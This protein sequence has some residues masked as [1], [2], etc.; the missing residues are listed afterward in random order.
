MREKNDN[1]F[2][3]IQAAKKKLIESTNITDSPDE[4]KVIDNFLFRCWQMGWLRC[5][6][7]TEDDQSV[8][9]AHWEL[10]NHKELDMRM[11]CSNCGCVHFLREY[12]KYCP[13]CGAKMDG[14]EH[15]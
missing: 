1:R 13:I 15:E 14:D 8:V 3:V 11:V 6:E 12:E 5:F 2:K 7:P 10:F 4:M 9:Y